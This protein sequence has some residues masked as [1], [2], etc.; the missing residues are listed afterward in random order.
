MRFERITFPNRLGHRFAGRIDFPITGDPIA[1]ALYAHC[2]T[3]TK[4]LKAAGRIAETLGLHGIAM[5]RFDFTGLGESEGDFP[6]T[7]FSSSVDDLVLAA[8]YLEERF[9]APELLI[10]HSLGG[11]AALAA[12]SMLDSVR[13]VVTVAAPATPKHIKRHLTNDVA[14]IELAGE[15]EMTLAG[16]PFTIRKQLLDDIERVR[17]DQAIATLRRP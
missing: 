8:Q 14:M 15:A 9:E 4:N 12:A 7:N 6:N 11:S 17:L 1:Y 5:L 3:C 10:G 16:R 13:A 2:F